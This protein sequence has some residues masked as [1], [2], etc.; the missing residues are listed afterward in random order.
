LG[1]EGR[2]Q[3]NRNCVCKIGEY[4][5][6]VRRLLLLV[7]IMVPCLLSAQNLLMNGGFE[8]ENIC[9]EYA[10][11]C[12]PE[13]WIS[14]SLYSDYYFDD[15]PNA[16]SGEHFI[17]LV[18]ANVEKPFLRNFL[19]SRLLCGLRKGAQYK[20]EFYI[21]SLHNAFDSIGIYFSSNDFLYQ[22]EKLRGTKPQLFVNVAKNLHPQK[23]WQKVSLL[24]TATGEE[25]FIAIGDFKLRGHRLGINPD[26]GRDFYF[27]LDE[28]S[29]TPVNSHER[30]CN[31]A[32]AIKE[33]EY[34]F[35]VRHSMLDRLV[36]TYTKSPPPVTPLPKTIAQ[37]IDTLV[38]P[39]VLFATN[40][41]TLNEQVNVVLDS[42]AAKAAQLAVDSVVVEGHTDKLGPVPHNQKLSENRASAVAAYLQPRLQ[43]TFFTR[44]WASE[45]PVANN[46]TAVGR[47]KNRRVEIYVYVRE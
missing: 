39:D 21:R 30:L 29:L 38:I 47:Q 20:L 13:G 12:A 24:Y 19:R 23:E 40:S 14:T 9:H 28:I 2:N 25:H 6:R 5:Y 45:K 18:L 11:N 31:E 15:K 35:N 42:L 41:Y 7:A 32:T 22:K 26:L 17:G 36:Y 43:T 16:Y 33:E 10:K 4:L 3:V 34:E 46:E 8:E 1:G 27:F 44:G 37:R